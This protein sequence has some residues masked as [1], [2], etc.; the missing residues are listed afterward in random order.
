M[1]GFLYNDGK[2]TELAFNDAVDRTDAELVWLHFDGRKPDALSWIA[3]HPMLPEF[4][5]R[6]LTDPE[7]RPRTELVGEGILVNLRGLGATPEDDPDPLVSLRFWATE[8]HVVSFTY[9]TPLFLDPVID[10]FLSGEIGDPGDLLAAFADTITDQL[11]PHIA[12]LGDALDACEIALDKSNILASRR[13]VTK[14][15]SSAIGYRRF[16]TPQ[17]AAL[18]ALSVAPQGWLDDHDR[19]HLREAADRAARMAEEL[20]SIRERA[21]VMHDQLADLRTEQLDSR[22]LLVSIIALIFL[23]LTFITGLLGMN[24]KGIPFAGEVWAFWGVVA[25]CVLIGLATAGYFIRA[26]WISRH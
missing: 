8:G 26:H 20:E 18:S 24:V 5:R 16:V 21:A 14:A 25:F 11:N 2:A 13:A 4:V 19:L 1:R 6:A 10:R 15:R 23:P 22:A 3:A 17:R 9:R 12:D 7:T